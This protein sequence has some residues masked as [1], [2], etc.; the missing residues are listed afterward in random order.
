LKDSIAGFEAIGDPAGRQYL[1]FSGTYLGVR[2]FDLNSD[3]LFVFLLI[4]GK[5]LVHN[6]LS[7]CQLFLKTSSTVY[8][9]L[10][11]FLLSFGYNHSYYR[12]KIRFVKGS[13]TPKPSIRLPPT[14]CGMT[15]QRSAPQEKLTRSRYPLL[16]PRI[17]FPLYVNTIPGYY[18]AESST[19][20]IWDT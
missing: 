12:I 3:L 16:P 9:I 20:L 19:N 8:D 13:D 7:L 10:Y 18:I 11:L 4:F 15:L 17:L 2:L 5:T 6:I 1:S 14:L